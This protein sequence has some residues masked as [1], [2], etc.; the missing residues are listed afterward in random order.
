MLKRNVQNF[1]RDFVTTDDLDLDPPLQT[2]DETTV[3]TVGSAWWKCAE[4]GED[5]FIGWE[6][7]SHC[8]LDA[9]GIIFID[10]LQ[11]QSQGNIMQYWSRL[12]KN[13]EWNVRNWRTKKSFFIK[14][15]HRLTLSQFQWQKRMN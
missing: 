13:C 15:T 9:Q 1:W 2:R 14:T 11:S 12:T 4:K 8:F 10:Y 6:G 7:D 5:R 3:E